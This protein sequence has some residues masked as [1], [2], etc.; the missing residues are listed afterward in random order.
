MESRVSGILDGRAPECIWLLEHPSLY[1]AGTSAEEHE[2]LDARLPVFRTGR[3]GH[4]TW[5]GPGQRVIYVMLDIGRRGISIHEFIR[6]LEEWGIAAL[7]EFGLAAFRREGHVGVWARPRPGA[8]EAKIAAIGVR[9]R[10]GVTFHG[11]ALNVSPDLAEFSG[12]IP[13]GISDRGVTSMADCGLPAS[14]P[15]VNDALRRTCPWRD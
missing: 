7:A 10:R 12:I 11:M 14:I 8:P 5:H 2:L 15:D 6:S 4:F 9:V 3:G 13:C 1:T